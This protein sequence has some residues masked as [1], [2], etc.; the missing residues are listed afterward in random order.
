MWPVNARDK[1]SPLAEVTY[2]ACLHKRPVPHHVTGYGT[3]S[4][5]WEGE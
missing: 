2:L 5:A 1:I 4:I 3:V